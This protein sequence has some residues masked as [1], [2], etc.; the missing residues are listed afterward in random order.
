MASAWKVI[1]DK[2]SKQWEPKDQVGSHIFY[3]TRKFLRTMI[4]AIDFQNQIQL[5][6]PMEYMIPHIWLFGPF[7]QDDTPRGYLTMTS[8]P[9]WN[10][11]PNNNRNR[12][13]N[14]K[15]K[16]HGNLGPPTTSTGTNILIKKRCQQKNAKNHHPKGIT[17]G[18]LRYSCT[19]KSDRSTRFHLLPIAFLGNVQ[20]LKLQTKAQSNNT[21]K[22]S[23]RQS[24]RIIKT[25]VWQD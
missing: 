20:R 1:K 11:T 7:S 24:G 16:N 23:N 2:S 10:E 3:E 5:P 15:T 14:Q 4:T 19:T 18:W 8:T 6:C 9:I 25:R 21:I 12:T 13:S 22:R 17:W